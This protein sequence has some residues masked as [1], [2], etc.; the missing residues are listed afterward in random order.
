MGVKETTI[1]YL[2]GLVDGEGYV[3]I[4]KDMTSVRNGHSKSPLYHERIQIRMSNEEAIKLFKKIFG[5]SYYF[6]KE[7]ANNPLTK[8][9][10]YCYQVSDL[11]A[12][13]TLKLLLPYLKIKKE[14]ARLCLCLRRNKES[15]LAH[16]KGNLGGRRKGKGR[17]MPQEVLN[18]RENL[19]KQIKQLN[20][21]PKIG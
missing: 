14:Q 15:K 4:K 6:E 1:S 12:A 7:K 18:Y 10:M 5:G 2:A 20:Q 8:R 16:Q 11:G 21:K 19:W 9:K 3:G 13:K 17:S